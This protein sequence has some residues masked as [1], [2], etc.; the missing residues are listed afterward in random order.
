MKGQTIFTAVLHGS[1][2]VILSGLGLY[3]LMEHEVLLLGKLT[4]GLYQL[5]YP[6]YLLI[7]S[8]FFITAFV[9]I[10]VLLKGQRFK[11]MNEWLLIAAL[12]LF[13]AG[14]YI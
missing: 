6:A 5:E 13:C 12:V 1:I 2:F 8:A 7:S 4:G 14:I 9:S 3:V 10:F 11:K